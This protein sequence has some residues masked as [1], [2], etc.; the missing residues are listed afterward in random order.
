MNNGTFLE[1][2]QRVVFD[3]SDA[4]VISRPVDEYFFDL[5]SRNT[6]TGISLSSANVSVSSTLT[7]TQGNILTGSNLLILGTGTS[8]EGTLIHSSGTI[9][10]NFQRWINSASTGL[11]FLFPVGTASNYRRAIIYFNSLT[12]GALTGSFIS[13]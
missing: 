13:G 9:V 3:G 10:G 1:G 5:E 4:Q 11:D 8:N 2:S 12:G 6:S 7:M